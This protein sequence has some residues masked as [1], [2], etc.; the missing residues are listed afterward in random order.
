ML[1]CAFHS[2]L[3]CASSASSSRKPHHKDLR[4]INNQATDRGTVALEKLLSDNARTL[5]RLADAGLSSSR[6][7]L[8]SSLVPQ[9]SSFMTAEELH[10]GRW[11]TF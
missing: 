4:V 11:V 1:N 5:S 9:L 8:R 6:R 7:T 10:R 2:K 3:R